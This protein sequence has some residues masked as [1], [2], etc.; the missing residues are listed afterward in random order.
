MKIV[1][2]VLSI[3]LSSFLLFGQ[4]APSEKQYIGVKVCGMCHKTDKQG[5]QLTIWE[6]SKHSKAFEVLKTEA[7]DKVAKDKGFNTP[8]SET[9]ECLKCHVSGYEVDK[10]LLGP[11]FKM[12]DGVQCETCH[13]PGSEY[14]SN[15]I[16]KDRA[17]AVENG[18]LVYENT[19]ALCLHCHNEESPSFKG[20]NFEEMWEKIKHPKKVK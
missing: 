9:P 18:L 5:S 2:T 10:A 1:I 15:E 7:A 19:E 13:G 8:A 17:L 16:M 4:S 6:N 11:K 14:K 3:L 12:E 20:F